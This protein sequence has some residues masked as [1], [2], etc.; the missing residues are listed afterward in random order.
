MIENNHSNLPSD[1]TEYL[2]RL[3]EAHDAWE[4]YR[5]HGPLGSQLQETIYFAD[6]YNPDDPNP[7]LVKH[8]LI[9]FTLA[10]PRTTSQD[11]NITVKNGGYKMEISRGNTHSKYDFG[12]EPE[13]Q[14][15]LP[16]CKQSRA[17]CILLL[18][19]LAS[20]KDDN[21]SIPLGSNLV[22]IS[23]GL[24][25]ARSGNKDKQGFFDHIGRVAQCHYKSHIFGKFQKIDDVYRFSFGQ[26]LS[27]DLQE[28]ENV[29]DHAIFD[30][31]M[32][33]L[34]VDMMKFLGTTY[35][36]DFFLLCVD[37]LIFNLKQKSELVTWDQLHAINGY[38]LAKKEKY[39]E[40]M[41]KASA[42]ILEYFP[43]LKLTRHG[44]RFFPE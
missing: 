20:Q 11:N 37:K 30:D 31:Y 22:M 3:I 39:I 12:R 43:Q 24:G 44:L 40:E 32:S 5:K 26:A 38:N 7:P 36:L 41:R 23:E 21:D 19:E 15:L 6:K 35:A 10:I 17:F 1:L 34:D 9:A 2:D 8:P 27:A 14:L 33:M 42:K 4:H 25:L 13:K 16:C 28:V 18:R 29:F